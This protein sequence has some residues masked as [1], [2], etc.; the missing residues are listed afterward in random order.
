MRILFLALMALPMAAHAEGGGIGYPTVSA[1][2]EALKARSDVAISVQGGW[3]IVE[4]KAAHA[5]WSFTPADHAAHPA[6]VRREMV[7]QG[8]GVSVQMT[9][10]C[11]ASKQACDKLMEEFKV[12]NARMGQD[13][14]S[15]W[16]ASSAQI[17]R[18]ESLSRLYFAAKDDARYQE[19]Y[20]VLTPSQHQQTPFARWSFLAQDFNAQ[21]GKL[22]QRDFKKITWYRNPPQAPA[23]VYAAVDFSG[24]YAN[25]SLYCGYLVLVEQPDGA[26]LILREEQNVVDK[27]T[28]AKLK[29]GELD[30][31]RAQFKCK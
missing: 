14:S 21:A 2:L 16:R 11:Q 23:G 9:A 15:Q 18:V 29:P 30:G 6:A 20:A 19:A 3:T 8:G 13:V 10:L 7:E 25:T 28:A 12:L 26:F 24:E 1:A 17:E 4:D 31:L 22:I 27:D 5:I